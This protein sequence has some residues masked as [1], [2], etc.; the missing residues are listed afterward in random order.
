MNPLT[1]SEMHDLLQRCAGAVG[2]PS[3]ACLLDELVPAI[4]KA[5]RAK[6]TPSV[7]DFRRDL[8][9]FCEAIEDVAWTAL[10]NE[11]LSDHEQGFH[12]GSRDAAK[13]LRRLMYDGTITMDAQSD[14]EFPP[15][16]EPAWSQ[17]RPIP[18]DGSGL[19]ADLFEYY[20]ADQVRDCQRAV[21]ASLRLVN[22]G[23]CRDAE[24]YRFLRSQP[25]GAPYEAPRIALPAN[26]S[27]G[28]FLNGQDADDI[29]D[30][31]LDAFRKVRKP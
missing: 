30:A 1:A 11:G 20:T 18:D 5:V 29:I 24:R 25:V 3:D 22:E 8:T 12:R 13:R 17:V 7:S 28:D 9:A 6:L 26:A 31:A 21:A 10:V 23:T 14:G 15:L 2:L 16:P 27:R 19:V 4:Q